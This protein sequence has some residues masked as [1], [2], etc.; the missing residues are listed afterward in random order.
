MYIFRVDFSHE[1]ICVYLRTYRLAWNSDLEM[2]WPAGHLPWEGVGCG[3]QLPSCRFP[4][5]RIFTG[6][7]NKKSKTGIRKGRGSTWQQH[8]WVDHAYSRRAENCKRDSTGNTGNCDGEICR[9]GGTRNI[10]RSLVPIIV[11][12]ASFDF[13]SMICSRFRQFCKKSRTANRVFEWNHQLP[14]KGILSEYE[15]GQMHEAFSSAL[16]RAGPCGGGTTG[17]TSKGVQPPLVRFWPTRL[18]RSGGHALYTSAISQ[19][20]ERIGSK[21]AQPQSLNGTGVLATSAF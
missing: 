19:Q 21:Q 14:G 17:S 15:I 18:A 4:G 3:W 9:P 10:H 6:R 16:D 11:I 13:S 2:A 8:T 5:R 12:I 1:R 20:R 7:T